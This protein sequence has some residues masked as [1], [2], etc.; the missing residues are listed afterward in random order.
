VCPPIDQ[1]FQEP[2]YELTP[3]PSPS[4]APPVRSIALPSSPSELSD[5][6]QAVEG[7][8]QKDKKMTYRSYTNLQNN[9][10]DNR[11]QASTSDTEG[12]Q[13]TLVT[14]FSSQEEGSNNPHNEK[15]VGQKK[16]RSK[17]KRGRRKRNP[18]HAMIYRHKTRPRAN[19]P[20]EPSPMPEENLISHV[21]DR[22]PLSPSS[23]SDRHRMRPHANKLPEPSPMP[24]ENIYSQIRYA[25]PANA[26]K[27]K[28]INDCRQRNQNPNPRSSTP[29]STITYSSVTSM[30]TSPVSYNTSSRT[31]EESS[32]PRKQEIEVVGKHV[33]VDDRLATNRHFEMAQEEAMQT[34]QGG[35]AVKHEGNAPAEPVYSYHSGS[36]NPSST[37]AV[38][39]VMSP[40][41]GPATYYN[42]PPGT[43][44][45]FSN[46]T[47]PPMY[48]QPLPCPVAVPAQQVYCPNPPGAP[49]PYYQPAVYPPNQVP[50]QSPQFYGQPYFQASQV[51]PSFNLMT[52]EQL[53]NVNL[54]LTLENVNMHN[55]SHMS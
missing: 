18:A 3:L 38:V 48:Y 30:E 33:D 27:E 7:G 47:Q 42:I 19:K 6:T 36:V 5:H 53:A 34:V 40:Q 55:L 8:Q 28:R 13:E 26:T 46:C 4:P 21:R 16:G 50:F 39:C 1:L 20:S 31:F 29:G 10:G 41:G 24:V 44:M 25:S 51:H 14:Y 32:D 9:G 52:S 54:P 43:N 49:Q 17:G 2:D 15:H 35:T 45:T 23:L 37:N 11:R 22:C 12:T